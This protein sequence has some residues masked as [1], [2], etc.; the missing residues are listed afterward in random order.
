MVFLLI[1]RGKRGIHCDLTIKGSALL[2]SLWG[3]WMG[4]DF[5]A[6]GSQTSLNTPSSRH[7]EWTIT[8]SL[9]WG[10]YASSSLVFRGSNVLAKIRTDSTRNNT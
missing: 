8:I 7:A 4:P 1:S 10:G 2:I 3:K 9:L 6:L 5:K